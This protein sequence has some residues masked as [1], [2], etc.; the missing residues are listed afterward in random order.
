MLMFVKESIFKG[1]SYER[2]C[3]KYFKEIPT[4]L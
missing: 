1:P 3:E 4:K 2:S